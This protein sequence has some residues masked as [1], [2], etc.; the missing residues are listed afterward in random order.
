MH[1]SKFSKINSVTLSILSLFIF[2]SSSQQ[3]QAL[4][5]N[6]KLIVRILSSNPNHNIIVF[7]RGREDGI[8]K[9]DHMKITNELGFIARGICI[10]TGLITS[11]WKMYRIVH[12]ERFSSNVNYAL[13]SMRLS[14]IA[15]QYEKYL[16]D[17]KFPMLHNYT[18]EDARKGVK[19]QQEVIANLDLPPEVALSP[20]TEDLP[21][22]VKQKNKEYYLKKSFNKDINTP[23]IFTFKASPIISQTLN[24]QKDQRY[25]MNLK[26]DGRHYRYDVSYLNHSFREVDPTRPEIELEGY[27]REAKAN[28]SVKE[29][30][31]S[32]DLFTQVHYMRR[33]FREIYVPRNHLLINPFGMKFTFLE[34]DIRGD[35]E[36]NVG[37]LLELRQSE[38][39]STNKKNIR[40]VE[41]RNIRAYLNVIY[42]FFPH[43]KFMFKNDF[44]YR[45]VF[46]F[47]GFNFD[48]NDTLTVNN[49]SLSYLPEKNLALTT[50]QIYENDIFLN[51]YNDIP[52]VN[53]ITYFSI[54]YSFSF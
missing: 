25:A 9:K 46:N 43:R 30:S 6:D 10:K 42:K 36:I 47:S 5:I 20:L 32:F 23:H 53:H 44:T 54:D 22:S 24:R 52:S 17:E 31:E 27:R 13:H 7:N 21:Q 48:F 12:P 15:P 38:Q 14:E 50:G 28:F 45:P 19:M 41:E 26:N 35:L 11:H 40:G 51:E 3:S 4:D 29:Y 16:N 49:L 34:D 2:F 8:R 33:K 37:P 18:D 1:V 39:Y